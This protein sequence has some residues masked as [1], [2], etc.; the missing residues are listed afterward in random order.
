LCRRFI[1]LLLGD[2]DFARRASP[3]TPF[4]EEPAEILERGDIDARIPERQLSAGAGVKHPAWHD[5]H[6]ARRRL[7]VAH[8]DAGSSLAIML[9]DPP[10]VQS[11]PAIMDLDFNPDTGRMNG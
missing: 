10:A 4:D 7:D 8:T 9:T 3:K 2:S 11:V 5:D 6:H 1:G